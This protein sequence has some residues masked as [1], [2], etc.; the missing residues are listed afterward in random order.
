MLISLCV[1]I[2]NRLDDLI[3]TMP[4]R[5]V[6][7]NSSPPVEIVILDYGSTDGLREYMYELMATTSLAR[8]S[9]FSYIWYEKPKFFHSTH[10]YN[11]ALKS[12]IGTWVVLTPADVYLK[13]GYMTILRDRIWAGC[14]WCNTDK[15]RRSTIAFNRDEFIAMG[16]YD[17]RFNT[18]GP[19]D[20]DIIERMNRRGLLRGSIPD[21]FLDEIYTEPSKKVANYK[22]D[23]SHRDLGKGLM[24]YLYQNRDEA[25]LVANAGKKWG[26]F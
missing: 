2:M 7:A 11:L 9:F 6:N 20:V 1:P 13:D 10:A 26:E 18:Y 23:L 15:K 19:D 4:D 12:G 3:A 24:R 16:G 22:G 8:G 14:Q 17:E 21:S 5:L 25:Q